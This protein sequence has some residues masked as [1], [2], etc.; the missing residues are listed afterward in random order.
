MKLSVPVYT[1]NNSDSSNNIYNITLPGLPPLHSHTFPIPFLIFR[2]L[3]LTHARFQVFA[4]RARDEGPNLLVNPC[5][6]FIFILPLSKLSRSHLTR[7]SLPLMLLYCCSISPP[8]SP[9]LTDPFPS[10]TSLLSLLNY[11]SPS[12]L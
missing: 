12:C 6:T 11:L 8:V 10:L 3:L 2:F 7:S 4:G 5:P 9:F 1:N